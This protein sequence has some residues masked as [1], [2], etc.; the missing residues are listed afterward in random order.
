LVEIFLP[1]HSLKF[2]AKLC[3]SYCVDHKG[4]AKP[5]FPED[6]KHARKMEDGSYMC[7]ICQIERMLRLNGME[8]MNDLLSYYSSAYD[9]GNNF[10]DITRGLFPVPVKSLARQNPF[11][12]DDRPRDRP[13]STFCS[14]DK[15]IPWTG[16]VPWG[17]SVLFRTLRVL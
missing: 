10:S 2:F 6:M 15:T 3:L 16:H 11:N 9:R 17:S 4:D 13:Q 1:Y 7:K 8:K 14:G 5:I 12:T